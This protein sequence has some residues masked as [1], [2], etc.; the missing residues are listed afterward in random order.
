M[1]LWLGRE[2]D[3]GY[4]TPTIHRLLTPTVSGNVLNGVGETEDRPATPVYHRLDRWGPWSWVNITFI[5]KQLWDVG[6]GGQFWYTLRDFLNKFRE[7]RRSQVIAERAIDQ[8]A[9]VWTEQLRERIRSRGLADDVGIARLHRGMYFDGE[10]PDDAAMP[11]TIIVLL[12]RMNY[13]NMSATLEKQAWWRTPFW[14][15]KWVRSNREVM[16]TYTN[17]FDAAVELAAWIRSQGHAA[18]GIGGA[19][20]SKI[21]ILRSAIEAGMGE[22]GKHGSIIHPVYGSAV[23][24]AVVLTDLPLMEDDPADFGADDFCQRCRICETAC[25]PSAISSEKQTVRGI[26]KWYVNFDRCVPYFNDTNGCG[27]CITACPWSRPGVAEKLVL[28]MARRRSRR[29]KKT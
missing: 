8:S 25:P 29:S 14:R 3:E 23:R 22:L 10:V 15:R 24:F 12:R 21:N 13:D 26:E 9:A 17:V 19:P 1:G 16:K 20:G 11:R 18:E 2:T 7:P 27:I 5:L 4:Q 6:P 28:K